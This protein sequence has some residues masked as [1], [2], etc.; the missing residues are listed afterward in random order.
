[1]FIDGAGENL[2]ESMRAAEAEVGLEIGFVVADALMSPVCGEITE[3]K[4][5]K[6]VALWTSGTSSLA[7]HMNTNML[8]S[9]FGNEGV[10]AHKE[11]TAD[12]YIPGFP[13]IPINELPHEVIHSDLS[14][15]GGRLLHL[16]SLSLPKAAAVAVNSFH[17]L[18]PSISTALN[19]LFCHNLLHIGPFPLTL[20][21]SSDSETDPHGCLPWLDHHLESSGPTSV[22]YISF[23]TALTPPIE[24]LIALTRALEAVRV[25][26]LWSLPERFMLGLGPMGGLGKVVPWAPQ[27]RV[28]LHEAVGA[29]VTHCGWNSV[30]ESVVSGVPMVCRPFDFAEQTLNKRLVE[31]IWQIGAAVE[32][33]RLTE[34]GA[35][36]A[37]ETVVLGEEGKRMRERIREIQ[38]L[39]QED[40]AQSSTLDFERLVKIVTN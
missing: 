11:E 24:E 37:V 38:R 35:A 27:R 10:E 5:A 3:E 4:A 6:W 13:P 12:K 33:G 34:T 14:S 25:P 1:M 23:G 40:S 16:M 18:E 26:F 9:K 17:R 8:R 22:A 36:A 28:L 2:R 7:A 15:T 20:S 39:A 21:A 30:V 31:S 19:V 32:D 29:H